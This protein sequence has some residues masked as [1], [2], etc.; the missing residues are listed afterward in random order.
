MTAATTNYYYF[1][2]EEVTLNDKK[3]VTWAIYSL[4]QSAMYNS[5]QC[6]GMA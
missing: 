2:K 1:K 3:I 6:S 4:L 5:V